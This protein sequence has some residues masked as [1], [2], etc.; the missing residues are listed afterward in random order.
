MIDLSALRSRLGDLAPVPRWLLGVVLVAA[1][2]VTGIGW[3]LS[4]P[5]AGSPD[6]DY[7]LGSIWCPGPTDSSGCQT[8]EN[9]G[10][11]E[12]L[13]PETISD[14]SPCFSFHTD[15][16]AA[17]SRSLSDDRLTYSTRYDAGNYPGGYYRFHHLFVG[18][19]V[20]RSVMIM[21]MVNLAIAITVLGALGLALPVRLRAGFLLA[22]TL[23]WMPMGVY[24][25]ASNNPS[26]WA[27]TGVLAYAVGL[28]ASVRAAGR[29][30][31]LLLALALVGALLCWTARGD[32]A[33]FVFVV[34]VAV[35]IGVRW[36][37]EML[38][39][40][41]AA[42][43]ASLVGVWIMSGTGQAGALSAK[44]MDVPWHTA[45]VLN[46]TALP[47]YL[48]GFWGRR[49][50]PGWFDVPLDGAATVLAL[51][52]AGGGLLLGARRM[53]WRKGLSIL[54]MVGAIAGIPL[55]LSMQSGF[56]RVYQYQP[57]Y[58]LP[59]LAFFFFLWIV[60][61]SRGRWLSTTQVVGLVVMSSLVQFFALYMV[62]YRYT[63][64]IVS[65][66]HPLFNL[67]FAIQWWWDLPVSP[68]TVW[69]SSSLAYAV[70]LVTGVAL[71]RRHSDP[72]T[73]REETTSAAPAKVAH[74]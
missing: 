16:S 8:R 73:E 2:L 48:A 40:T 47:E 6:D 49:W 24:F 42:G 68:M 60:M 28:Y 56:T 34:S 29:R 17:C 23:A 22:V 70:A 11:I 41:V 57:R 25:I 21:R 31:W 38:V 52:L 13:V 61:A 66:D 32:S 19:D 53:S 46:L 50:G 30:R 20:T 51:S 65:I 27:L 18:P 14:R 7:H 45:L 44:V 58:M 10:E 26:S 36:K 74:A 9:K 1:L 69:M 62:L 4:S 35:F 43:V 5:V 3:V 54:V 72:V 37:R 12:I 64:G 15:R 59:L 55:V 67:N 39:Q 33:F 71:V 63:H